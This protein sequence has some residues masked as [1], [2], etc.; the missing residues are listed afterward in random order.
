MRMPTLISLLLFSISG[1]AQ[2]Q[3]PSPYHASMQLDE[4]RTRSCDIDLPE[5]FNCGVLFD[6]GIPASGGMIASIVGGNLPQI[7]VY[8]AGTLYTIAY[9]P[10]LKRDDKF[11]HLSRGTHVAVRIEKNHL[12]LQ[13]PDQT[14][15]RGKI[16]R[17]ES[18]FPNQPQPA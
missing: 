6:V 10:P 17:R 3:T 11:L 7:S 2:S 15:C 14:R 12:I 18:I 13:W 5:G 9:D 4:M 16:M 8:L 1:L